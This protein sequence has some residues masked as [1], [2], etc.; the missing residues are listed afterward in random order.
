M[1]TNLLLVRSRGQLG[2]PQI[3]DRFVQQRNARFRV[4]VQILDDVGQIDALGLELLDRFR[5]GFF[6]RHGKFNDI[7][8]D[9]VVKGFLS[10][11]LGHGAAAVIESDFIELFNNVQRYE[12]S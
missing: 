6:H 11:Y 10:D 9:H 1:A 3:V 8:L 5:S 2:G 4:Y 12:S 7:L